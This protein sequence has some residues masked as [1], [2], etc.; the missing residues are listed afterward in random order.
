MKTP[1]QVMAEWFE[2]LPEEVQTHAGFLMYVGIA[3][4]IGDKEYQLGN[5]PDKA[6]LAWLKDS[7]SGNLGA[8][9]KTL[10][11]REHIRF[12]MIDGVCTQKNWDEALASNQWLL[13]H[14]EDHPD[15]ERM[16]ETPR[17]MI[18]DIPRRSSV[19]IKAGDEWRTNV[20]SYVSDEAIRKWHEAALHKSIS[21]NKTSTITVSGTPIYAANSDA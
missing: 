5:A 18:A 17:Q 6:F 3:D 13:D 20:A 14:F 7:P 8:L 15:A 1:M 10:L 2:A 16:K 9:T 4:L 11:A 19:F 12:T 21:E